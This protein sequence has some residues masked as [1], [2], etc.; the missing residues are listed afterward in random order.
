[1][2]I[3]KM[4]KQWLWNWVFNFLSK[5]INLSQIITVT[6]AGQIKI[7]GQIVTAAELKSIQEEVKAF[8]N[9]RLKNILL[10]TPKKLAEDRMFRDSKSNDDLLAGKL[11]LYVVDVQETVLIKILNAPVNNQITMQSNPYR[12]K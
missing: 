5:P 2:R 10:N 12:P 8:Q 4:F 7:D 3:S 1:M 9:F 11:T 6:D